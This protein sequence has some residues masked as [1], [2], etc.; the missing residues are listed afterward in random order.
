MQ[1]L[2]L[3]DNLSVILSTTAIN[4]PEAELLFPL[5]S[6]AVAVL[7]QLSSYI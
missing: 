1:Q 2:H 7:L 5:A 3:S 6:V 4:R